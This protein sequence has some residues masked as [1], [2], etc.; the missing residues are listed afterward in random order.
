MAG[1][2]FEICT[3]A[4]RSMAST[5]VLRTS[6]EGTVQARRP[7]RC[8]AK[9]CAG[10]ARR[11]EAAKK[12]RSSQSRRIYQEQTCEI[13]SLASC[14]SSCLS[15]SYWYGPGAGSRR[16][17]KPTHFLCFPQAWPWLHYDCS[18]DSAFCHVCVKAVKEAKMRLT[19]GNVKDSTFISGGFHNWKDAIPVFT[20]HNQTTTHKTA[21]EVVVTLPHT[22]DDVGELLS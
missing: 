15:R 8:E 2:V 17:A 13:R 21:T 1:P 4:R 18:R 9:M 10:N 14:R 7:S 3:F 22:T 16:E 19:S 5:S 12:T 11:S 6:V 20:S